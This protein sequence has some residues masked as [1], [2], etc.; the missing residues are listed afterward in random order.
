MAASPIYSA[1]R[2]RFPPD[3]ERTGFNH[4]GKVGVQGGDIEFYITANF[5]EDGTL[6]EIF[7]KIAKQGSELAGWANAWAITVSIALQNGVPWEILRTKYL[8]QHFGGTVDA[9]S[10]LHAIAASVDELIAL[11]AMRIVDIAKT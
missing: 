2:R 10:T 4:K 11:Y 3:R 8:E 6:G 5:F 1:H 9:P 7:V